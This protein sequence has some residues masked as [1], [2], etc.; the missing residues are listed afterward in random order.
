[1]HLKLALARLLRGKVGSV[2]IGRVSVGK[3]TVGRLHEC[4]NI[5][6]LRQQ[7]VK[8]IRVGTDRLND[9]SVIKSMLVADLPGIVQWFAWYREFFVLLLKLE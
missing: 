3:V 4:P 8:Q 9:R 5:G 6:E 1:L 7:R 2:T